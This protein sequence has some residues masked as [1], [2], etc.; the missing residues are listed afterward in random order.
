MLVRHVTRRFLVRRTQATEVAR[1]R[2]VLARFAW[3]GM[4][5]TNLSTPTQML[6]AIT[7]IA[8]TLM[9]GPVSG[10]GQNGW[11]KCDPKGFEKAYGFHSMAQVLYLHVLANLSRK[12]FLHLSL[13]SSSFIPQ[14]ASV[15]GLLL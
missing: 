12:S 1:I 6:V 4:I 10:V 5:F 8:A 9:E 7:I 14:S 11:G 15:V 3:N 13:D 2:R